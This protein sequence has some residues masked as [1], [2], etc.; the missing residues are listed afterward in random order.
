MI[1]HSLQS[2]CQGGRANVGVG[3]SFPRAL[4]IRLQNCMGSKAGGGGGVNVGGGFDTP[5]VGF[6][7][8]KPAGGTGGADGE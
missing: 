1:A 4:A 8:A 3:L 5:C 7:N 2:P 6:T